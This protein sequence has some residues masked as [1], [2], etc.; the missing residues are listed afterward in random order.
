[1]QLRHLKTYHLP[2]ELVEQRFPKVT[3]LTSSPNHLR[4]ACATSDRYVTLYDEEG[5]QRDKFPTK[6]ADKDKPTAKSYAVR[7]LA[8][9]PDS[10][11]LAVAQSDSI[12]FV[13]KLGKAWSDKKT[14]CNKYAV[15][16]AVTAVVWPSTR[17]NDLVFGCSD[18]KVKVG[19]SANKSLTLYTTDSYVV[20]LTASLDGDGFV[21]GHA[22]GSVC[23]YTF[24]TASG[25]PASH[26]L[27][28][29]LP[30]TPTA[31]AYTRTHI[32]CAG[33]S[34]SVLVLDLQGQQT[35][36]FDYTK[37]AALKE[38][39]SCATHPSGQSVVLGNFSQLLTFVYQSA[40]NRWE[41]SGR[42]LVPNLLSITAM[43]WK[44]DGSRLHTGS[45]C[46]ALDAFDACLRRYTYKDDYEVTYTA[47]NSALVRQYSTGHKL[48]L[49]SRYPV[50]IRHLSIHHHRF[51]LARTQES[52]LVAD[53]QAGLQSEVS[54]QGWTGVGA[55][56][57]LLWDSD[58][59]CLVYWHGD[60]SV[61]EYGQDEVAGHCRTEYVSPHLVSVRIHA[62]RNA[63]EARVR[64]LAYLLDACTVRVMTMTDRSAGYRG[65]R[66]AGDVT[67]SHNHRIDWLELNP[68][69]TRLLFRDRQRG[70]WVYDLETGVKASL[71]HHCSYVQW[72]PDSDVV[73]AQ[74]RRQLHVYYAIDQPQDVSVLP[75]TGD[76]EQIT[77]T[78]GKTEVIVDEG[79]R[80]VSIALDEPLIAFGACTDARDFVQA[81]AI[82]ERFEGDASANVAAM[83]AQLG[84][85]CMAEGDYVVAER[86]YAAM[87][88][89]SR[90]QYLHQVNALVARH[91]GDARH[92]EVQASMALLQGDY[93]GAETTLLS[94]GAVDDC[95]A[96]YQSM[97]RWEEALQV[98]ETRQWHGLRTL[99]A[100]YYE[101]LS[102][103]K[104]EELAG[105]VKEKEGDY[106]AALALYLKGGFAVKAA[107]L[108][109]AQGLHGDH[110]LCDRVGSA[111]LAGRNYEKAG[112]FLYELGRHK[113]ALDAYVKGQCYHRAVELARR[114]FPSQVVVLEEE[115]GDHLQA[116]GQ[117][118]AACAHFIQCGHTVKAMEAALAGKQFAKAQAMFDSLSK[119]Q[120]PPFALQLAQHL[121]AQQQYSEAEK[122]FVLAHAPSEAVSMYSAAGLWDK[123]HSIAVT[124]MTEAQVQELYTGEAQRLEAAGKWKEAEKLYVTVGAVDAAIAMYRKH[125][126]YDD[127]L[128]VIAQHRKDALTETQLHLGHQFETEG[129][130]KAAE[131][132]YTQAK[133]WKAAYTMYSRAEQW[134]EALRVAKNFG[135]QA[136][137]KAAAYEFALAVG[138]DA[139][140]KML[141]K[142]GL[143]ELA[144]DVA[145]ERREWATAF[146]IAQKAAKERVADVH[147]QYAMALEDEGQFARAEEEF[148]AARK[149]KEAIDMYLHQQ[150]WAAATRVCQQNDLTQLGDI[151]DAQA[152]ALGEAKDYKAA[153]AL[154]VQHKKAE[155]AV[156]LYCD[157]RMWDEATRVAKV[158]A[159][160]LVPQVQAER[161]AHTAQTANA[162]TMEYSVSQ[163]KLCLSKAQYSAAIDHYLHVTPDKCR[164]VEAL[165]RLWLKAVDM[166]RESCK[167]RLQEVTQQVAKRL[168][169]LERYEAVAQLHV[170]QH[171]YQAAVDA[172][173]AGQLWDKAKAVASTHAPQLTAGITRAQS[174]QLLSNHN[175]ASLAE[176]SPHLAIDAYANSGEWGKV[177]ELASKQ[178]A[179]VQDK[180]CSLHAA[181]LAKQGKQAS[182]VRVFLEH[183]CPLL[184]ANFPLYKRL[185]QD[186][187]ARAGEVEGAG[188][189]R[190]AT[191]DEAYTPHAL[192]VL[193]DLRAMLFGLM[194]ELQ[195]VDPV[196]SPATAEL[197][198]LLLVTHLAHLRGVCQEGE[199]GT[200]VARQ[201]VALLR[202]SQLLPV[203]K[204]FY[205]AGAACRTS[206]HQ[207]NMA[208]VFFNRF[209][210]LTDLMADPEQGDIDHADFLLTD[211]PSPFETPLPSAQFYADGVR[212]E[213]REW[214]LDKAMSSEVG[215]QVSVRPCDKCGKGMYEAGLVCYHCKFEYEGCIVTGYPIMKGKRVKC[216]GCGKLANNDDW[217]KYVQKTRACPWCKAQAAPVY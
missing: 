141:L 186:V 143:G 128:R 180:Y 131:S 159:A 156:R 60:L 177:H 116:V 25:Q 161:T 201:S 88:D 41:E 74:S 75:I 22:D 153:E 191:A 171:A 82:L 112:D 84:R 73:V 98:A 29:R 110:A 100:Q 205:D 124:Y 8:F 129:N 14:I 208:F 175:L 119:P 121:R 79:V 173:V 95:I 210:D 151:V 193:G 197:Q 178:P 190:R 137:Y 96:M 181:A 47:P 214:V 198:R 170:D 1:M 83:W 46:G 65:G 38:F 194:R 58:A 89:V 64:K 144:V 16:A 199:L 78:A 68:R 51:V 145:V 11:R 189:T 150:D 97:H 115:W 76:V 92:Y 2:S 147:L 91:G 71:L 213:A 139:G 140:V 23:R 39:T 80:K 4:L 50:D 70:V 5:V 123:A 187:L 53:L 215:Q 31:L 19:N 125:R 212:E 36:R 146:S 122:Y 165:E 160:R 195:A 66:P 168:L 87:G 136:A 62:P 188:A 40:G 133:E 114:E 7:G 192:Q 27:L 179:D 3:A 102:D 77:R 204:C 35:Q 56:E 18:G 142:R 86:C 108:I 9:S 185:A 206:S 21:S 135:G 15:T 176:V 163:A 54:W 106:A 93:K 105:R 13:Y 118:D 117:F 162:D 203:D 158:H 48:H 90:A 126:Q 138:G 103:T 207:L 202:Y 182:A 99:R 109:L 34:P 12:V 55:K 63:Q 209:V 101:Y 85:L 167:A 120:Q 26:S 24:P 174:S 72:V 149:P 196:G 111:L 154:L 152:K 130:F 148:V 183:G 28:T 164:D 33:N 43:A 172:L 166:A 49:H 61:I 20:A 30:F 184:P 113:P 67:V 81:V 217:N 69:G 134:E 17:M 157:A 6:A 169:E 42:T 94:H 57:R 32:L 10:T 104:Q 44:G 211:I 216:G 45:L 155:Q 127:L 132:A 37:E 200:L 52:L 59:A 107:D